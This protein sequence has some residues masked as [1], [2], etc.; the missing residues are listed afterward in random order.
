MNGDKDRMLH[1]IS[2]PNYLEFKLGPAF[3]LGAGL[4]F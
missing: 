3:Q 1:F 4:S 2:L